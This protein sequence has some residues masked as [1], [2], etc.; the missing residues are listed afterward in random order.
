MVENCAEKVCDEE[1]QELY[2]QVMIKRKWIEFKNNPGMRFNREFKTYM[3][4]QMLICFLLCF[5]AHVDEGT[6][7]T[8]GNSQGT[9]SLSSIGNPRSSWDT[10]LPPSL[11][12]ETSPEKRS[13]MSSP[14]KSPNKKSPEKSSSQVSTTV[15]PFA[16]LPTFGEHNCKQSNIHLPYY[17]RQYSNNSGI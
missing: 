10:K 15:L 2:K 6:F 4:I 11:F 5:A 16:L 1:N 17:K 8:I 7:E 9:G 12:D 14:S 3:N 13:P